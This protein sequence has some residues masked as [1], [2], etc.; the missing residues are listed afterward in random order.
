MESN[1]YEKDYVEYD[2][3]N[4]TVKLGGNPAIIAS[5]FGGVTTLVL[6]GGIT[7]MMTKNPE[8]TKEV[9]NKLIKKVTK[10]AA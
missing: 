8:V 7:Y 2:H 3:V 9:A 5:V 6:A 1:R 4:K 10:L